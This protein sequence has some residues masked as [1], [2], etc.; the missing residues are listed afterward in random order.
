MITYKGYLLPESLDELKKSCRTFTGPSGDVWI[1]EAV[2]SVFGEPTM[3][4]NLDELL[5]KV[6]NWDEA[7]IE[8]KN[9][10]DIWLDMKNS[11]K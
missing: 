6:S 9:S 8:L 1:I 3:T 2:K 11:H 5:A 10:I 4:F 7:I